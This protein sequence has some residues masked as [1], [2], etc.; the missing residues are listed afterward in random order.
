MALSLATAIVEETGNPWIGCLAYGTAAMAGWSRVYE[1]RHWTSDVVAGAILE[2]VVSRSTIRW[3]HRRGDSR[4]SSP[5]IMLSLRGL[6]VWI[7]VW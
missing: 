2:T 1:N 7:P 6:S 5:N 4:M 3:F